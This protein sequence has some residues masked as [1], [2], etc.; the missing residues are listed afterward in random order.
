MSHGYDDGPMPQARSA[1]TFVHIRNSERRR[2]LMRSES[3]TWTRVALVGG[4]LCG[5]GELAL[6]PTMDGIEGASVAIAFGLAFLAGVAW[7]RR[8][9]VGGAWLIAILAAIELAFLPMY[10]RS[11]AWE[12]TMQVGFGVLSAIALVGAVGVIVERRR[13]RRVAASITA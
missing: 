1:R 2:W 10:P 6:S 8:G 13:L 5:L 12:W 9:S 11:G 3:T 4:A 7:L